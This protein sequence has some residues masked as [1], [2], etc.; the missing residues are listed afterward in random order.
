MGLSSIAASVVLVTMVILAVSTL[1]II[2]GDL[3]S[4]D[5]VEKERAQI[6]QT[7]ARSSVKYIGFN[8]TN[9][10]QTVINVTIILENTGSASMKIDCN[11]LA[12][13]WRWLSPQAID[14]IVAPARFSPGVWDPSERLYLSS[15]QEIE[16]GEHNMTFVSCLGNGATGAFNA[17]ICGD[18]RCEGGEYCSLDNSS[19]PDNVCYVPMCLNGCT[20]SVIKNDIDVGQCDSNNHA[21]QCLS[22]PCQCGPT[23]VCCGLAHATCTT[24]QNC[25]LGFTCLEGKC[26]Q[27]DTPTTTTTTL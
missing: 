6:L 9:T 27:V 16:A 24:E 13:D 2:Y 1:A 23:S 21:G 12:I 10:S 19:C 26:T 3:F 15:L 8:S 7:N 11:E 22:V 5:T 14:A 18:L 17:S 20:Q 4:A 25:C